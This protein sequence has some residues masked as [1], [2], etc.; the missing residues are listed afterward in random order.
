MIFVVIVAKPDN[1][2]CYTQQKIRFILLVIIYYEKFQCR[3]HAISITNNFVE[4]LRSRFVAYSP[5]KVFFTKYSNLSFTQR[6]LTARKKN[7]HHGAYTVNLSTQTAIT[8]ITKSIC[9]YMHA[10]KYI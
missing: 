3:N 10:N 4:I 9:I 5:F 8:K 2:V 6:D 7:C 1:L